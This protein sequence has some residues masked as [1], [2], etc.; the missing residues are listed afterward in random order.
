MFDDSAGEGSGK[1]RSEM[2]ERKGRKRK[3]KKTH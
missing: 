3:G 1:R 2:E